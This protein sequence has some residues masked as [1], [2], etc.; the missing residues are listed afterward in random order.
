M[1][2]A[3]WRGALEKKPAATKEYFT[4]RKIVSIQIQRFFSPLH[5]HDI[6]G[7]PGRWL[8]NL[9]KKSVSTPCSKHSTE[10][11][12]TFRRLL[13]ENPESQFGQII[14]EDYY[15]EGFF[16]RLKNARN[17]G[18]DERFCFDKWGK[19]TFRQMYRSRYALGIAALHFRT[20]SL[21]KAIAHMFVF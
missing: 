1:S 20:T 16:P 13:S 6:E 12:A 7:G 15:K 21:V 17:A 5:F 14:N 4:A 8:L 18:S 19:K 9:W 10:Y 2:P 11:D 3:L